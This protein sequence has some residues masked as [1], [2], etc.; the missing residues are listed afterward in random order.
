MATNQYFNN[1]GAKYSD[2]RVIEDIVV[3]SIKIQGFDAMYL[4]NDNEQARDLLF[5]EDPVKKFGTAYP[6]EMYLSTVM[7]YGGEREFFSKFGLEIKNTVNVIVSK[8]SFS[9]RVPSSLARPREGDLVYVPVL[10]GTGELFEIKF[11]DHT[12]DFFQLGRSYP[13]FYELHLEKFKYS[14][15][16]IDTGIPDIDVN[17]TDNS[18]TLSLDLGA[19]SGTYISKEIV[20]QSPNNLANA[21]ASGTLQTFDGVNKII[22]VTN[23]K[24][25]FTNDSKVIGATSNAQYSLATYEP[26]EDNV[27]NESYQNL[28]IEQQGNS[29]T[30]FSETNPF[31]PI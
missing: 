3:E 6:V 17:V 15:E 9:Q 31:G 28:Y 23:V 1:Y 30:D 12:K 13:F 4:P 18:Y 14:H 16:V 21:T 8:R 25:E 2:Q 19:G 27:R 29:I 20:F 24:G 10:N 7:E 26:L 11:V 5:G 22:T